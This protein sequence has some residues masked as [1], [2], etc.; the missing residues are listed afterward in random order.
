MK[1]YTLDLR[2][3]IVHFVQTGGAKTE[4][5]RRYK[6]SRK[7]VYRYLEADASQNLAPKQSWGSWR[8]LDPDK[9]RQAV[10]QH[11]DA[12]LAEL[13]SLFKVQPMGIWHGLKRLK[14]T[15]KKSRSIP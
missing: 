7:T 13:A 8:K 11:P 15:L 6:V 9:V 14:I 3:R 2:A 1:A 4:A 12:T 5:A 10:K